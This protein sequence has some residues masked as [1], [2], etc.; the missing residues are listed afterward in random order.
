MNRTLYNE[1]LADITDAE[2]KL[3]LPKIKESRAFTLK[4][5]VKVNR[6]MKLYV[7]NTTI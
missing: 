1:L 4:W 6:P 7:N 2:S 5:L 3:V